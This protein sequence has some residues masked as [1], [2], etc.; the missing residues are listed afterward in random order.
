M[1]HDDALLRLAAAM[2]AGHAV[3]ERGAGPGGR[4]PEGM[5][6]VCIEGLEGL[7]VIGLHPDEFHSPQPVRV[8]LMAG[9]GKC[10]ACESDWIADTIDYGE[11][12]G[13]VLELMRTHRF[14]LLEGFAGEVARILLGRFGAEWVRVKVVKPAKFRDVVSVGV[15]VERWGE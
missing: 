4:A 9:V 7:T 14:R 12:R 5:D 2:G 13:V 8:D 15:V 11:V 1:K 3:P 6:F 10:R